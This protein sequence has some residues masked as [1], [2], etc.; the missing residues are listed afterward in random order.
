[1]TAFPNTPSPR[2]DNHE[3][4]DVCRDEATGLHAI[5][6][7]HSTLL[8]P[9]LGGLRVRRHLSE[10][11]ALSEVF[12]L[13]RVATYQSAAAG[14]EFGGGHALIFGDCA[15]PQN[16]KLWQRFGRFVNELDGQFIAI[17]DTEMGTGDLEIIRTATPHVTRL[18]D[19]SSFTALGVF[20]SILAAMQ[21][22]T[23]GDDLY[24]RRVLVQGTGKVGLALVKLLRK[25][26]ATVYAC[27]IRDS[28]LRAAVVAGAQ[29]VPLREIHTQAVD[30]YAPCAVG[31]ILNPASIPQL[32]C[33]I[34][35]GAADHQLADEE[36]DG[37]ALHER[38]ILYV[39]DFIANAGDMIDAS[40]ETGGAYTHELAVQRTEGIR[41]TVSRI[42]A[43]CD[44]LQTHP[45]RAAM[46]GAE[47]RLRAAARARFAS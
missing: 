6:A 29:A 13:S 12:R 43:E 38:G 5:V 27:D 26:G 31:R 47:K 23:G 4:I 41:E 19:P 17:G 46:R 44:A 40:V 42:F 3:L 11:E 21:R 30:V 16:A 7:V 1:M 36:R 9:A 22:L 2:A 10:E 33:S 35:A 39:P 34:V 20:Y 25:A 15:T 32:R 45:H 28:A 18:G 14:L 24:G 37:Q 8:G